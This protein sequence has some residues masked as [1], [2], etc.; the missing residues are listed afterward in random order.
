MT[1]AHQGHAKRKVLVTGASGYVGG[2]LVRGLLADGLDV[3]V[4]VRD[5]R[6]IRDLP[7]SKDVDV[8]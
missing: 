7:W 3:R 2:R 6:K 4:M 8:V 5:A 1:T